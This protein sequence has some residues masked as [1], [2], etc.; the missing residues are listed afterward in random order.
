MIASSSDQPPFNIV[1]ALP[2]DA[3]LAA[4]LIGWFKFLFRRVALAADL[5]RWANIILDMGQTELA[6]QECDAMKLDYLIML[7]LNCG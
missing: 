6:V 1:R 5:I 4:A 2:M 3:T 7:C